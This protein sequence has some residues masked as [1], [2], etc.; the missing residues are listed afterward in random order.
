MSSRFQVSP[1]LFLAGTLGVGVGPAEDFIR[2]RVESF[3]L[4]RQQEKEKKNG[5]KPVFV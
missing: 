3:S 5:D 4:Q 2:L 1:L